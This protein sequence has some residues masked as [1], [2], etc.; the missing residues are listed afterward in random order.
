MSKAEFVFFCTA[1]IAYLATLQYAEWLDKVR[2]YQYRVPLS[3]GAVAG[4]LLSLAAGESQI[5]DRR[6]FSDDALIEVTT[7]SDWRI[8]FWVDENYKP[9]AVDWA[10]A[11]DGA[12]SDLDD[13][14]DTEGDPLVIVT[15]LEPES[16]G[17]LGA[18]LQQ[19]VAEV[20]TL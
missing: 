9:R 16:Y 19:T 5:T 8:A 10:S 14:R 15:E 12:W 1:G 4:E 6:H 11:P 7:S 13:W 20:P 2:R 18:L 17:R 3:A